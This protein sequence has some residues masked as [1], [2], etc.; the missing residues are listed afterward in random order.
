MKKLYLKYKELFD[1]L[2]VGVLTTVIS[3]AIYYLCIWTFADPKN[4]VLL[5]VAN[6]LSWIVSVAFAYVMSRKFVFHSKNSNI[7]QEIFQFFLSRAASLLLDMGIMFV[8]V[9]LM[10]QNANTAKLIS[11]VVVIIVNY[12]LSKFMV[13]KKGQE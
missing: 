10:K 2:V 7:A 11:Q 1:Y 9:T 8:L 13:F 5:Q 4:A 6:I 3:L 12:I